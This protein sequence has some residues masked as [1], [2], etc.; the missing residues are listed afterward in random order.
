MVSEPLLIILGYQQW[1][2]YNGSENATDDSFGP[3]QMTFFVV[4]TVVFGTIYNFLLLFYYWTD[5]YGFLLDL[6][7][8]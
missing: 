6:L 8:I 7:R 1:H 5:R 4:V 3:L 2:I